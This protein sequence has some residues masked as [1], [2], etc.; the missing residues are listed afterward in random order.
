MQ[1][2][3]APIHLKMYL[4]KRTSYEAPLLQSS[5]ASCHLLAKC[6]ERGFS[7]FSLLPSGRYRNNTENQITRLAL[8][9]YPIS[10]SKSHLSDS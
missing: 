6:P 2:V 1:T 3:I 4:M 8:P 9:V 10:H 7:T 5:R